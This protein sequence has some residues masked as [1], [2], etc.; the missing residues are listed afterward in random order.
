M[1]E[2]DLDDYNIEFNIQ[3][4]DDKLESFKSLKDDFNQKIQDIK[5]KYNGSYDENSLSYSPYL[6]RD[7]SNKYKEEEI[8]NLKNDFNQKYLEKNK[9]LDQFDEMFKDFEKLR[10]II[11]HQIKNKKKNILELSKDKNKNKNNITKLEELS[12]KLEEL[13]KKLTDFNKFIKELMNYQEES[14]TITE[15]DLE[16]LKK[17]RLHFFYI[18]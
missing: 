16:N 7:V 3:N 12:E 5:N 4:I 18:I 15:I 13:N 2:I 11:D 9:I 1:R 6:Q 8:L 14:S 10:K 17:K